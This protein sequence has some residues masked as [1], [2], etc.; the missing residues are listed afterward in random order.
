MFQYTVVWYNLLYRYY[1]ISVKI[2]KMNTN[3]VSDA[4]M[5]VKKKLFYPSLPLLVGIIIIGL[6]RCCVHIF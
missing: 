1:C 3:F 5:L 4:I 6:F 2:E